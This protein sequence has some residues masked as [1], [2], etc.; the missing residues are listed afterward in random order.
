MRSLWLVCACAIRYRARVAYDGAG[1]QGFQY[2]PSSRT[3]QGELEAALERRLGQSTRVVAAGR[4][5]A[6]VHARGQA[7]HFDLEQELNDCEHVERSLN[8][9]LP[10][11]IRLYHLSWA[12][13]PL[14]KMIAGQERTVDWN[15]MY[16]S[17]GKL[18]SY[19]LSLAPVMEPVDRHNRW[20]PDQAHLVDIMQLQ[21][22]LQHFVGVH[23]FR[24]F[25]GGIEQ[26]ER[27]LSANKLDTVREVYDI[28]VVDEGSGRHRVDI[29]LKGALYKQVRNMMGTVMDVCRSR[30]SEA[31][32]LSLLTGQDRAQNKSKPAPPQGLTLEH[33]CFDED[34]F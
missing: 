10:G 29:H 24:A 8:R 26:L 7:V 21:G 9:M 4:T 1:Y 18:Y 32:F 15:V 23:D 30:L 20:H 12:P 11:D 14:T 28:Q 33:V 25:S 3:V 34:G 5:D 6:G 2:Q 17:T 22:L 19:R 31:A 16:D 13:P 27:K